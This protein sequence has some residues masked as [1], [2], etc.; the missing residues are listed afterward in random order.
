MRTEAYSLHYVTVFVHDEL[1][2][3]SVCLAQRR[4]FTLLMCT[5]CPF[6]FNPLGFFQTGFA[7][8]YRDES[9]EAL[10]PMRDVLE[11]PDNSVLYKTCSELTKVR[12]ETVSDVRRYQIWDSMRDVITRKPHN[13]IQSQY[14]II[15][16]FVNILQGAQYCG[17][18]YILR[19]IVIN[20]NYKLC[21]RRKTLPTSVLLNKMKFQSNLFISFHQYFLLP[22]NQCP[23]LQ[24]DQPLKFGTI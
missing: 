7:H 3:S 22:L 19:L 15:A 9:V 23:S 18:T 20:C 24:A 10:L 21:P 14:D 2:A 17:A 5:P 13:R 16:F 11:N 6:S 1:H 8:D 12:R 4:E